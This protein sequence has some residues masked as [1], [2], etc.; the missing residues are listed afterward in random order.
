MEWVGE[1]SLFY[2]RYF[3]PADKELQY[4]CNIFGTG[5]NNTNIYTIKNSLSQ[6]IGNEY[7]IKNRLVPSK[8]DNKLYLNRGLFPHVARDKILQY[9]EG[10][11]QFNK[12]NIKEI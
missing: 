9:R 7:Y 8:R 3:L 2:D 11:G 4:M 6:L 5:Y 10:E 12:I 1:Y